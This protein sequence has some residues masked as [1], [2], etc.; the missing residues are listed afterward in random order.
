M[1][2]KS[3]APYLGP[4]AWLDVAAERPIAVE[5][6]ADRNAF[7]VA[8][9]RDL[10]S[11]GLTPAQAADVASNVA[12]ETGWGRGWICGNGG[13]WKITK[14]FADAHK[15]RTGT[16]APWWKARGNVDSADSAW[17]FY[18]CFDSRAAFLRAWCEQFVP[19]PG[20]RPGGL[21][22]ATGQAFWSGGDWFAE[23][24]LAGYKGAP[25]KKKIKELRAQG[26]GDKHPSVKAHEWIVNEVMEVWAQ[27]C[28][29]I[30]PDGA[31]GP[32][33]IAAMRAGRL[34]DI[35]PTDLVVDVDPHHCDVAAGD[36]AVRLGA[37]VDG[38]GLGETVDGIGRDLHGLGVVA[39]P[40]G[41]MTNPRT[42]CRLT[43]PRR[44]RTLRADVTRVTVV[45]WSRIPKAVWARISRAWRCAEASASHSRIWSAMVTALDPSRARRVRRR[46]SATP[47]RLHSPWTGP[48][49]P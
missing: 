1:P 25:S 28:L 22:E 17:C 48:V 42:G 46:R 49:A 16:P 4:P 29:G 24:I 3:T 2:R 8:T 43:S 32:K 27:W 34:K 36:E 15:A 20:T 44:T 12:G 33:S 38:A 6:F 7:C 13:G 19:R 40:A 5:A 23:M 37:V 21:Y 14:P 31:W 30:D 11:L 10:L 18:R 39:L 45:A 35:V 47:S 9:L 26:K 41:V